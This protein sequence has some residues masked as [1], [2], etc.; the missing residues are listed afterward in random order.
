MQFLHAES[1]LILSC[2]C[3]AMLFLS[4]LF[5]YSAIL[6]TTSIN[7][8][9]LDE[10]QDSE[11]GSNDGTVEQDTASMS[12]PATNCAMYVRLPAGA[13]CRHGTRPV[14]SLAFLCILCRCRLLY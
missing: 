8:C 4:I 11:S 7:A 3:Y 14:W 6:A 10:G 1:I 13:F 2:I 5:Y 12:S 9:L